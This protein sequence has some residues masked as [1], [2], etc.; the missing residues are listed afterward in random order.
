MQI[1]TVVW[2][3]SAISCA[4]QISTAEY[5]NRLEKA[6]SFY[7]EKKFGE[8]SVLLENLTRSAPERKEAFLWLGNSRAQMQNWSAAT[9][10]Y[11]AYTEMAPR[12]VEGFR[13]LASSFEMRGE[14]DLAKLYY[15]KALDLEP[16]NEELRLALK[17]VDSSGKLV[18]CEIASS[19]SKD[20]VEGFWRVGLAGVCK[21]RTVWWGRLIAIVLF[22]LGLIQSGFMGAKTLAERF[23]NIP[24]AF[25][26][27]NW[28]LGTSVSYILFWGIP[29]GWGWAL[30]VLC[31]VVTATAATKTAT[32]R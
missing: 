2:L 13:G 18:V 27:I 19:E 10:A 17:R 7:A 20:G 9:E 31:A 14:N 32:E 29:K 4:A 28:I 21:A 26:F 3:W 11:K 25:L 12:D 22:G 16:G 8:A 5:D 6:V 23:P 24:P 30:L 1:V 15:K